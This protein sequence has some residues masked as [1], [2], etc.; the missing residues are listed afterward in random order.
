[1]ARLETIYK[2]KVLPALMEQYKYKSVM[3]A[4]RITKITLNMGVG[5]A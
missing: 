1:M 4:P 3:E 5:E 2:E